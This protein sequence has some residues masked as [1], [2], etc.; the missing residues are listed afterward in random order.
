MRNRD[1]IVIGEHV[2]L[3]HFIVID[4]HKLLLRLI[5]IGEREL[6]LRLILIVPF[7]HGAS[8]VEISSLMFTFPA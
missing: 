8:L 6:L 5:L 3:L 4:E 1:A 2:L 7:A